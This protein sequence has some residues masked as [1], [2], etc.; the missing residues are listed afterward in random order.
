MMYRES[1]LRGFGFKKLGKNVLISDRCSIYHPEN[2][3]IGDNVR[4]DDFCILSPGSEII[5][6]NYIHIACYVSLIGKGAITLNDFSG[7][8]AR[9]TILSS[10]DDFSGNFLFGPVIPT[11]YL[12]VTSENVTL[13]KYSLVGVGSVI[14]PGVILEEGCVVG[15]LSLVKRNIPAYEIWGGNP[16]R[17]IKNR[18]KTMVTMANELT[19][20][21]C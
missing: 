4:I 17:F 12:N 2:I 15:A 6:G 19:K 20:D 1:T 9:S 14:L 5:I 16:L 11:K 3:S 10:C 13:E 21:I 7:V 18:S 8:S